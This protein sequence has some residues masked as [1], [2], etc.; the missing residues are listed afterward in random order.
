M[1]KFPLINNSHGADTRNII[2]AIINYLNS[3]GYTYEQLLKNADDILNIAK[4]TNEINEDTMKRLDK[5]IADS[6]TSSTEVVDARGQHSVLSNRLNSTDNKLNENAKYTTENIKSFEHMQS[7]NANDEI[8]LV[9]YLGNKQNI[10]PKVLYFKNGWNG[11]K[12]W[13]GYTPYPF[14][15]TQ[16][17]NPCIAVSNDRINWQDPPNVTNPLATAPNYNG[18]NSDTHLVYRPDL[19]Q[20]EIWYRE[21][22]LEKSLRKIYRRTSTNGSNWSNA[23]LL[24]SRTASTDMMSPSP[25]F[26]NETGEYVIYYV[27]SGSGIF[28]EETI[29]GNLFS[30]TAREKVEVDWGDLVPWHMDAIKNDDGTVELIVSAYSRHTPRERDNLYHIII[31]NDGSITKPRIILEPTQNVTGIDNVKIYRSCL[32]KEDDYYFLYYSS[33]GSG[34]FSFSNSYHMSLSWGKSLYSLN[35]YENFDL[36]KRKGNRISRIYQNETIERLDVSNLDAIEVQGEVTINSFADGYKGKVINVFS[37]SGGNAVLTIKHGTTMQTPNGHDLIL[38][39]TR[40]LATSFICVNLSGNI[41]RPINQKLRETSTELN[42]PQVLNDFDVS[43]VDTLVLESSGTTDRYTV[44]SFIGGYTGKKLNIITK[45]T[46]FI[47]VINSGRLRLTNATNI[48]LTISR[49]GI[50]LVFT[51]A[52]GAR[53]I[54]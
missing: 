10:H 41:W 52:N 5:I 35:G 21:V 47:D 51:S 27:I 29:G 54:G 23:E 48:E 49:P 30:L 20:L 22:D 14:G 11:F 34:I 26:D 17:E 1:V 28:K 40:G 7:G 38:T 13:M 25:Y 45:G 53:M 16:E 46:P 2:N 37:Q 18:Y 3:Q 24:Y 8:N 6:G 50:T 36:I 43:G 32:V 12:Y 19:D 15:A 9:N 44:N 4:N 33:V 42:T 31:N 39:A